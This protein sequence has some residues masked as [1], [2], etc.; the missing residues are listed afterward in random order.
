MRPHKINISPSSF[1]LDGIPL[2]HSDE[3]PT[4]EMLGPSL[5][6]VHLTIYADRI[7]I[8]GDHRHHT[9]EPTPI[10]DQLKEEEW[11]LSHR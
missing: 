1:T 11:K 2:L 4:W 10:Y 5:Y 6:R 8:D 9:Q 7:Q 3:G